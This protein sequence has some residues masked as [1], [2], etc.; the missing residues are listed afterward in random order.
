MIS[1]RL[2]SVTSNQRVS[3]QSSIKTDMGIV[4]HIILD[5]DDSILDEY[6]I[7]NEEKSKLVG[8]ILFRLDTEP[9]KPREDL[10]FAYPKNF[11]YN[12]LPVKNEQV[13]ISTT[14]GCGYFYEVVSTSPFPN[15]SS[16]DDSIERTTV[17]DKP[18]KNFVKDYSKVSQTRIF[19]SIVDDLSDFTGFGD[20]F[21]PELDIH[22]LKLYEGDMLLQSRFGQS[23]RF[24]GYNNANKTFSP[25]TILRNRESD[26][27]KNKDV[28]VSIE[29]DV[30][31][32]GGIIILSSGEY[33]LKF[34]PGT[35]SETGNSDF[36]TKPTS[37]N[38]YPNT[39]K[40]NQILLNSDRVILS[41]KK[42][43]LIFYSKKNYGFISDGTLSIDNKG[44]IE[45]SLGADT[46]INTNNNNIHLN[47]GKGKIHLGNENLE[48]IVRGDTLLDL[49]ENLIDTINQQIFST[50]AGPTALGPNNRPQFDVIKARLRKMLS[51]QNKTS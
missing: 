29:E 36:R 31:R 11:S 28:G 30:N 24:S 4:Y 49:L 5:T 17:K 10:P 40:G 37:F 25:T 51:K 21:S 38:N 45:A 2:L 50:P 43:E 33:D 14:E 15:I 3:T 19:R 13:K 41:A 44:G 26:L 35:V 20:Y 42:E 27:N 1:D 22:T 47:S 23:F 9:N 34:L 39:L 8:A 16:V 48:P 12:R 32:D 6:E 7:P 46:N 18:T